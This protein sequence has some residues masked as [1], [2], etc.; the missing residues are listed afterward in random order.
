ML[1]Y[2]MKN[3]FIFFLILLFL[4][5]LPIFII[6]TPIINDCSNINPYIKAT[7]KYILKGKII[8]I[9]KNNIKFNVTE[10][11]NTFKDEDSMGEKNIDYLN[12]SR[13]FP[14]FK[15]VF[16]N[17]VGEEYIIFAFYS[18]KVSQYLVTDCEKVTK[19]NQLNKNLLLLFGHMPT[20]DSILS[21]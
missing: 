9:N 6:K 15:D 4:Y 16:T 20:K 21:F 3:V 19:N 8:Q 18:P 7:G 13:F 2:N 12:N 5:L 17:R 10:K 1:S 14:N 11:Y